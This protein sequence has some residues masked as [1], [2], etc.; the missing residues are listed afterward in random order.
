MGKMAERKDQLRAYYNISLNG[1]TRGLMKAWIEFKEVQ[2]QQLMEM[3][4]KYDENKD[5]VLSLQE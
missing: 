4:E 3:F 1:F 2:K 5:Q